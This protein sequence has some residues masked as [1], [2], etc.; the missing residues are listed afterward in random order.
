MSAFNVL[1]LILFFLLLIIRVPVGIS[2]F[3]GGAIGYIYI[4]GY[5][6][7]FSYLK[8]L[9]FDRFSS[10]DLSVIPIFFLMGQIASHSGLAAKLFDSINTFFGKK[11]YSLGA[12]AITTCA[13]FGAICGSSVATAGTMAQTALP[14]LI[15]ND[16]QPGFA[17]GIIAAGGTLG[18]LIPPSVPLVIYAIYAEVNISE[19]FLSAFIPGILAAI[20][21]V[22]TIFLYFKLF[23]NAISSSR[24]VKKEDQSLLWS[25]LTVLMFFLIFFI[26][27]G[28]I[29]LGI[30]SPTEAAGMSALII[31][32]YAIFFGEL[33]REKISFI[34]HG[35]LNQTGMVFVILIGA[36]MFN[37]YMAVSQLPNEITNAI[38]DIGINQYFILFIII[39]IYLIL[40]CF[41]D[42]LAMILLTLPIFLPIV[43]SY[44]YFGLP[45]SQ[46]LIWFGI[47]TLSVM[48]IGLITPPVGMNL[49]VISS[50]SKIKESLIYKGVLPFILSDL[51]RILILATVP[52]ISLLAVRS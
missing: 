10:Y 43:V 16:Y 17:A 47:L 37:S 12:G 30:F 49:F 31:L 35:T 14:Q 52:S 21:Y 26:I 50:F 9:P 38:L 46:K 20:M 27:V 23:K 2:M 15:K 6:A 25:L 40:G 19:L 48:E 45:L 5:A 1:C 51:V 18:I 33:N 4:S 42:S 24:E 28:G 41:L 11:K 8:T 13:F 36:D 7:F 29:Y 34:I 3:V 32:V 22:I 44:D 39:I